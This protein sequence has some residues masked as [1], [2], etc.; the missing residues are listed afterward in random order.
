MKSLR[1]IM[2]GIV[3]MLSIMPVSAQQISYSVE[4]LWGDGVKHCAFSSLVRFNGR[5]YC[6]FRE[7][8]SHIFDKNGKAE[9]K[10]RI[11]ASDEFC[12]GLRALPP[13]RE[14]GKGKL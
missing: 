7:G 12:V 9:G 14:R 4:K 13:T 8:E 2:I 1:I 10:V 6:S 3:A 5:Y 11:L